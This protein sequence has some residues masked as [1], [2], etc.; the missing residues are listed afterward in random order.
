MSMILESHRFLNWIPSFG[1]ISANFLKP[2]F[3]TSIGNIPLSWRGVHWVMWHLSPPSI[4]YENWEWFLYNFIHQKRRRR[5]IFV[6]NILCLQHPTL[7]SMQPKK[8][9]KSK[10]NLRNIRKWNSNIVHG[11]IEIKTSIRFE[12]VRIKSTKC[13]TVHKKSEVLQCNFFMIIV[14]HKPQISVY[15]HGSAKHS[16]R[17]AFPGPQGLRLRLGAY[18]NIVSWI[19]FCNINILFYVIIF[20]NCKLSSTKDNNQIII[21]TCWK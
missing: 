8:T 12:G 1:F 11:I 18:Q 2:I 19:R 16:I 3:G 9:Q 20:I 13:D 4:T 17:S 21:Y 10:T 15:T 7:T 14:L 5:I 6:T